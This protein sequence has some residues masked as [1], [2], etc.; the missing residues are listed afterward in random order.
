MRYPRNNKDNQLPYCTA[1]K[2][3]PSTSGE[4]ANHFSNI[5]NPAFQAKNIPYIVLTAI[6]SLGLNCIFLSLTELE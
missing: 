5:Y 6:L 3:Y 1:N 2:C 4:S